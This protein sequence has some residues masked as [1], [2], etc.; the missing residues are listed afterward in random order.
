MYFT[1][2]QCSTIVD[3]LREEDVIK[4]LVTEAGAEV[5]RETSEHIWLTTVCHGGDSDKL[6]Y[7][8]ETKTF[9][10]YTHCGYISLFSMVMNVREC[11]FPQSVMFLASLAHIDLNNALDFAASVPTETYMSDLERCKR[12]RQQSTKDDDTIT[13]NV[14]D[15]TVLSCFAHNT[16]YTGWSS[17]G[18]GVQA[19][20]DF[21]IAWDESRGAIIIPH[22]DA[23]GNL[24]G[25]RRRIPSDAFEGGK[26]VPLSVGDHLYAH[27]LGMTL[28]GLYEHTEAIRK[29]KSVIIFEGEKSVLK[30]HTM[31]GENSNA[32]A[33][34]GFNI[35]P[36]QRDMI[37]QC[38]VDEVI[39]A[40]DK[41]VLMYGDS[42]R[43]PAYTRYCERVNSMG[44]MFAPYCRTYALVDMEDR[45]ELK[46]S[47][48]DKGKEVFTYLLKT[49]VPIYNTM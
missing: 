11:D 30:H 10:C 18:I 37:L 49:K 27:P 43:S 15:P 7:F 16:F 17:E 39:L 28:Y 22:K 9:Y 44:R 35:T 31:F 48:I 5:H 8:R 24:V 13:L 42:I 6:C 14:V 23:K 34:C 3:Q 33:V 25:I 40:F 41:E 47:P 29:H 26:Y 19:M 2:E 1:S 46:D 21:G 12:A 45:L 4:W 36:V 38:G 32:V 20:H